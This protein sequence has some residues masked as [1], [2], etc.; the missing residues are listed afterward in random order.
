MSEEKDMASGR[1][2]A[3]VEPVPVSPLRDSIPDAWVNDPKRLHAFCNAR[4]A[5]H[6]GMIAHRRED[7]G[8]VRYSPRLA[9]ENIMWD[10][11]FI[12]DTRAE[13][14]DAARA[15]R[16]SCRDYAK[17]IE[18]RQGGNAAGGAV[19]ES[20]VA[21]SHSPDTPIHPVKTRGTE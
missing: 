17:A 9:G 13:A 6:S 3:E 1:A 11:E 14:L 7:L 19:H 20:A 10:G 15:F 18:A 5:V 2:V 16:D 8:P 12:F 4:A 21:E